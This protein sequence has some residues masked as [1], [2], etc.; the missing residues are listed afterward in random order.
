M[1]AAS[2]R[3]RPRPVVSCLRCRDKKLRCDRTAPCENCVKASTANACTYN[4]TGTIPANSKEQQLQLTSV[5]NNAPFNSLED[6]QHRMAVVE[7]L[8]GVA[9]GDPIQ[10]AARVAKP[11]PTTPLPLLGTVVVKG[12]RS[13]Y[14]RQ[15]GRD[16]FLNQ[17]SM[18]VL[19]AQN[20][21]LTWPSSSR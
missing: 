3:K 12:N 8:L 17:V 6:L 4:Q 1:D 20:L 15:N 16:T 9:R 10:A 18:R 7:E 19:S 5:A 21:W 14:H 13:H 2:S 11:T